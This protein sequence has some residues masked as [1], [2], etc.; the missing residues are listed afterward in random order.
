MTIMTSSL[1]E[2]GDAVLFA[3]KKWKNRLERAHAVTA[4]SLSLQPDIQA[5]CME[6]LSTDNGDLRKLVDEVISWL[7]YPLCPNKKWWTKVLM[8]LLILFGKSSNI[9]LTELDLTIIVQVAFENDN[10]LSCQSYLRH[11]MHPLPIT[12]VLG[13]VKCQT[14]SK[15]LGIGSAELSWSSVNNVKTIKNGKWANIGGES[16]E[17]RATLYKSAK[18]EEAQILRILDPSRDPNMICL[19]TM[20][21][22]KFLFWLNVF[23]NTS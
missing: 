14:T 8:K 7:H 1:L 3:W 21:W 11:E 23:H 17:K 9:S 19:A 2:V 16:L 4:W 15:H 6:W 22:S 5:V 10:A 13:F 12:V 20:T 18:L